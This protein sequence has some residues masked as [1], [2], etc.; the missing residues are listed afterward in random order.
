M[1]VKMKWS[2]T[3][4]TMRFS[5]LTDYQ[6]ITT[7][8]T[9]RFAHLSSEVQTDPT[10]PTCHVA[11]IS[12]PGRSHIKPMFGFYHLLTSRRDDVLIIFVLTQEWRGFI[13]T[14]PKPSNFRLSSIP[15]VIPSELVCT[16]NFLG[17]L[18][19]VMTKMEDPCERL[20]DLLKS[21]VT[22]IVTDALLFW[23]MG[24]E[25]LTHWVY[26]RHSAW[27]DWLFNML[28]SLCMGSCF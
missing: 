23:I 1:K 15:N 6:A 2:R 5:P 16:A 10:T 12:Y 19:V 25:C 7:H 3:L 21:L 27:W 13:G 24:V 18:E 4:F 8:P 17:F 11:S 9:T 28:I 14:D 20:L 26:G 22:V